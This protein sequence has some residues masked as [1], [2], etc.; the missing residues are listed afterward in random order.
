MKLTFSKKGLI[1]LLLSMVCSVYAEVKVGMTT[2]LEG[3]AKGLGMGVQLGVEAYFKKINDAG[4]VK[5]EKIKLIALDDGYELSRAAP[6]MRQLIGEEK[7]VAVIGNVGTPTATVT[8]PIANELKTV[9]FG[10]FTGAGLLR[11]NP[12]RYVVN[13]RVSYAQETSTMINGLLASGIKPEEIAFLHKQMA[14]GM[15]VIMVQYVH[16]KHLDIKLIILPTDVIPEI[17]PTL[18]VFVSYFR[19]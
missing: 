2:A 3:P 11:K 18:R 6:N 19:C 10:A 16:C 14:M 1:F 17:Q 5:G 13:Y 8:V 15:Q 9:L 7:V 12:D 4:G